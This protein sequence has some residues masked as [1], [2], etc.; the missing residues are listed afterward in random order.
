MGK[1]NLDILK[2]YD[3]KDIEEVVEKF[4]KYRLITEKKA[5]IITFKLGLFGKAKLTGKEIADK[6]KVS[7]SYIFLVLKPF[8]SQ[9]DEYMNDPVNFENTY[10]QNLEAKTQNSLKYLPVEE[11]ERIITELFEKGKITQK[12]KDEVTLR[13]GLF[14]NKSH[15][16]K[17]VAEILGTHAN[18][19]SKIEKSV[20]KKIVKYYDISFTKF[21]SGDNANDNQKE[22]SKSEVPKTEESRSAIKD[23]FS[24][25][26]MEI[27]LLELLKSKKIFP[28]EKEIISLKYG[29][30]GNEEHTIKE[31]LT[32]FPIDNL[33]VYQIENTFRSALVSFNFNNIKI[34]EEKNT[35]NGELITNSDNNNE[36]ESND[37]K[38][39]E[40]PTDVST[41]AARLTNKSMFDESFN[42]LVAKSIKAQKVSEL[43]KNF[44]PKEVIIISLKFGLVDQKYFSTNSITNFLG[45]SEEEVREII[46]KAILLYSKELNKCI[47][48]IIDAT[49]ETLSSFERIKE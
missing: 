49:T 27:V 24:K 18:Y 22:E 36:I 46:T 6:L 14:G 45:V 16:I 7:V 13:Y 40:K 10:M 25:K 30:F 35:Q 44:T 42:L 37:I 20:N 8:V 33:H 29:L 32:K 1:R 2:K 15:R 43:L 3:I 38:R 39:E 21:M 17:E 28:K 4:L 5:M 23:K 48:D 31:I 12:Q 9:L 19:C 41:P 11:M 47:D 26:Q 34:E